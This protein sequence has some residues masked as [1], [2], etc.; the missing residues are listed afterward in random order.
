MPTIRH[1]AKLFQ[2]VS[3]KDLQSAEQ[4]AKILG[5]FKK[6]SPILNTILQDIGGAASN[7][8]YMRNRGNDFAHSRSR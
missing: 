8:L 3:E 2:A 4:I 5:S 6:G 7:F 1:L